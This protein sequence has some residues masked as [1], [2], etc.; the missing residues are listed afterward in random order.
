MAGHYFG[1]S[2]WM[3]PT[4]EAYNK[5]RQIMPNL[6]DYSKVLQSVG[7]DVSITSRIY[8]LKK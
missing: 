3:F 6:G 1:A 2:Q 8:G 5:M 7:V 4:L